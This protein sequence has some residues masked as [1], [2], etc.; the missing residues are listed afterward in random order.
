MSSFAALSDPTRRRIVEML[1][2]GALA[3]GD[4]AQRFAISR[5]AVSQHLKILRDAR[6]VSV[7]TAG[8]QRIYELDP[9]GLVEIEEWLDGI[10]PVWQKRLEALQRE[11]YEMTAAQSR[12]WHS[13]RNTER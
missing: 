13:G 2:R 1:A 9:G 3:A 5:S 12:R 7:R 4:I 11:R 6:L 10:G 8:Q